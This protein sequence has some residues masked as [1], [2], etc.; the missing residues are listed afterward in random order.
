MLLSKRRAMRFSV[1]LNLCRRLTG[2]S[3]PQSFNV[4]RLDNRIDRKG[5]QF[6][7]NTSLKFNRTAA[8]AREIKKFDN[9]ANEWWDEAGPFKALHSFNSVR[10]PWI[11]DNVN[12]IVQSD[13]PLKGNC[14]KPSVCSG[15]NICSVYFSEEVVFSPS[16]SRVPLP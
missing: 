11:M 13:Q 4:S 10:V 2:F 6:L 1:F 8:S 5:Y 9:L 12:S 16:S 3:I 7:M 15:L 14:L